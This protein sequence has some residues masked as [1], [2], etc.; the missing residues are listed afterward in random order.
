M[1]FQGCCCLNF[2]LAYS[3]ISLAD[4][5]FNIFPRYSDRYDIS[6]ELFNSYYDAFCLDLHKIGGYPNFIQQ[7]P[8]SKFPKSS[9]ILLFQ[10]GSGYSQAIDIMWADGGIGNFFIEQSHLAK[11]DFTQVLYNWDCG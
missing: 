1:P 7:D 4:A 8:R 10:I 2:K 5:K 6:D 11:L 3:P 9:L